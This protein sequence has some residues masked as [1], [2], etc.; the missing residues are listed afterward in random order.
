[1]KFPTKNFE[2]HQ[3]YFE[4][5]KQEI[6]KAIS[7]INSSEFERAAEA[8]SK[9]II[10]KSTIFSCGNGGS[11]SIANHLR[12]DFMKGIRTNTKL[13]PNVVS[14]STNIE[15][16]TAISNDISFEEIFRYQLNGIIQKNDTLI[17]IS[18]S[19]NS[20]NIIKAIDVAKEA[21]STVISF[22]GFDGGRSSS[23]SDINIHVNSKNYGI[24]EDCHQS[25]MHSL[26]Q[27][28]RLKHLK[29]C[30]ISDTYF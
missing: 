10:N 26:A 27:T 23:I 8:I 30:N 7:S 15:I 21:G 14:L 1:M 2:S 11:A 13:I 16:I 4:D 25:I 24:T 5:Y 9:T 17:T 18:S 22:T 28:I 12:C 29:D 20:E 3:I 6:Q 19:G